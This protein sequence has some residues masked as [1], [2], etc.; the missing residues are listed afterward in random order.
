[1]PGVGHLSHLSRARVREERVRRVRR[2]LMKL[3][4]DFIVGIWVWLLLKKAAGLMLL[5]VRVGDGCLGRYLEKEVAE[6]RWSG[7]LYMLPSRWGIAE[8]RDAVSALAR[9]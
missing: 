3:I 8:V 6:G 1:M 2:M 5:R 4:G 7:G 9:G